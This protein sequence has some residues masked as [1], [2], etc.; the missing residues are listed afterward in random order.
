VK[1]LRAVRVYATLLPQ[2][3]HG[4]WVFAFIIWAEENCLGSEAQLFIFDDY[5]KLPL[6]DFTEQELDISGS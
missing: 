2:F 1:I 3:W 4:F 6:S 5:D